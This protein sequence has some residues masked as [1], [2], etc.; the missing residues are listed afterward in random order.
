M[1]RYAIQYDQTAVDDLRA[2]RRVDQ[3]AIL[4]AIERHLLDQPTRVSRQAIKKLEPPVL[5]EYRLRVGE[6]RVFYDVYEDRQAVLVV[7]VRFKGRLTL[8]EAGHG[9]RD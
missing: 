3:V 6:Y 1:A 2:L 5:A 4:D 7:A 9:S 8:D